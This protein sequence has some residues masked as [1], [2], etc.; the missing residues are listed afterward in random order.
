[1]SILPG[2]ETIREYRTELYSWHRQ[3]NGALAAR[4]AKAEFE[5]FLAS[6][7]ARCCQRN[8]LTNLI[9]SE[10]LYRTKRF[11]IASLSVLAIAAICYYID[12]WFD[13]PA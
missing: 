10:E 12:Y 11:I 8:W 3:V 6:S 2:A 4:D 13:R 1:M 9:R 5:E 7:I